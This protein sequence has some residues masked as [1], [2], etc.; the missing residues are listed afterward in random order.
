MGRLTAKGSKRKGDG[1]EREL[2]KEFNDFHMAETKLC[3]VR[4]CQVGAE[5]TSLVEARQICAEHQ[6]WVEAKRTE[7]IRAI[8]G[9]GTS[10]NWYRGTLK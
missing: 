4:R 3:F 7:K 9:N 8:R 5:P 2:A 10:R 6:M 1:Y